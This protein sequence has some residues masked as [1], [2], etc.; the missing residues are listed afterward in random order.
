MREHEVPTHVQAEDKVLLGFTF[1][2]IVAVVAVCAVSYGIYRYFP[3]G[4]SEFRL[5]IAI[6]FG[7]LGIALTV[8][9]VGG[10]GLPLV[11]ADLLKFNLGARRYAGVPALL[12]RSEAPPAPEVKPDPLRLLAKKAAGGIGKAV[13][14][15]RRKGRPPF[16]P[17]SWFGKRRPRGAESANGGNAAKPSNRETQGKKPWYR[18]LAVAGLLVLTLVA[19]P[20]TALADDPEDEDP[21]WRLDE[22]YFEPP[23]PVPGRR[24]FIEGLAVSGDTARVS[25]RAAHDLDLKVRVF[26]G[27]TGRTLKMGANAIVHSGE[28]RTYNLTLNG[29]RPSFTF[30]WTDS[31]GFSGAVSLKSG[32]IPY[33]LPEY[34]G[35]LCDLEVTSLEWTP[36]Q[37]SGVIASECISETR[38]EVDLPVYGGHYSQ[39]VPAL[40]DASVTGITGTVTVAAGSHE[41]AVA[42]APNGET[43]FSLAVPDR[44]ATH[45]LEITAELTATLDVPLPPMLQ[46][47]HHPARTDVYTRRV[48]C[49]CGESTTVK[50]VTIRVHHPEHVRAVE[51]ERAPVTRTRPEALPLAGGPVTITGQALGLG[52]DKP[53]E[54]LYVPP[55]N[56]PPPRAEQT[57]VGDS[58]WWSWWPW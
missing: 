10:R 35:G 20:G 29:P 37:I 52:A 28:T 49:R 56:P 45:D 54:Y 2:Q 15:A 42:F 50:T 36:G 14:A 8:G 19:I 18:L 12:A 44:Q 30:S 55:P 26:G 1:P 17:H 22:I 24:I 4:P 27:R 3:F 16:R 9:K 38:Q 31:L 40:L 6:V 39:S 7:T 32:Q 47:V 21:G 25:L 5:G 43:L 53:F 23:Q 11:A 48:T 51:V 33:P 41:T 13:R 46:T 58:S 34:D 57:E